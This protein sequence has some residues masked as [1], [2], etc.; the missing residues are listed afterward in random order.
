M[1]KNRNR[2]LAA[3]A[4]SA[5]GLITGPVMAFEAIPA[6]EPGVLSLLGVGGVVALILFIRNRRK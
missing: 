1:K 6:P 2:I 4:A 3:G 5:F